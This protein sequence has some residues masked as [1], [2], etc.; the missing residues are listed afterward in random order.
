MRVLFMGSP[1]EAVAPLLALQRCHDIE[2]VGV[3]S[4]PSR[5]QGRGLTAR[6]TAVAQ[7]ANQQQL[8]L[9]QPL[10]ASADDFVARLAELQ[11][12]V[13]VT[14]AYGQILS[15]EFLAVAHRAVINIHPS[16]LPH[17]RGAT[18][19]VSAIV[20]GEREIGVTI[21][22]TIK[23]LD[24]GN[25]IIQERHLLPT[26]TDHRI[27][28]AAMFARGAKLLPE[29]LACLSR[30]SNYRGTE[31][32]EAQA[33]Y[34]R[35]ITKKVGRIV[36]PDDNAQQIYRNYL[37]YR[38]WPE[39][40]TTFA[41]KQLIFHELTADNADIDGRPGHF[42]FDGDNLRVATRDGGLVVRRLQIAGKNIVDGKS[43]WNG[44]NSRKVFNFI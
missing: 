34:C 14:A 10:K 18:P 9:Y 17:L 20:N 16:Y 13:I 8:T 29:A 37:A 36:W 28:T 23:R 2:I 3:V 40:Y 1:T 27:V 35:K 22:F 39:V 44:A 11:I 33:S 19:V 32:D 4:Q 38:G 25:I 31:Q 5:P 7:F 24:A 12:D 26:D 41:G 43:F 30:D 15:S 21:C 42:V 6:Q